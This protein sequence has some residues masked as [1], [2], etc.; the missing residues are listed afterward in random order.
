MIVWRICKRRYASNS[1]EGE[2]A[3]LFGGRWNLPGVPIVYTS[4]TLSLAALELLVHVDPADAPADLVS[5]SIEVPD[6]LATNQPID[7]PADW[8]AVPVPPSTQHY[9]SEWQA[10]A[11]EPLLRLPSAVVPTE[12]NRLINPLHP[13]ARRVAIVDVAAF[14]LDPRLIGR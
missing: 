6:D 7:L 13:E 10:R 12:F 4:E 2:G 5:V 14:S 3:R 1:L 9:G 11:R 8:R